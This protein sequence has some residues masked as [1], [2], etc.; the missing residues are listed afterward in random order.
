MCHPGM[1]LQQPLSSCSVETHGAAAASLLKSE[2]KTD[3]FISEWVG[4]LL[5][6]VSYLL[7]LSY[8]KG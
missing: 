8:L 6:L 4:W 5:V 2:L 3:L 1:L 7:L